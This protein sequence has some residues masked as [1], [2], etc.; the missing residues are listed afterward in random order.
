VEVTLLL[1]T[2]AYSALKRGHEDVARRVRSAE[3]IVMSGIIVGELHS[4]SSVTLQ[5]RTCSY[6]IWWILNKFD[7]GFVYR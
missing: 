1:D 7:V 2:K 5:Q 3:S 6:C 4:T